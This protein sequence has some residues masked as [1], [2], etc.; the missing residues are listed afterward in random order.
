MG[1]ARAPAPL[2]W[3]LLPDCDGEEPEL[4]ALP[5]LVAVPV[6]VGVADEAGYC[7]PSALISKG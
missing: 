2:C 1:T 5:E 3:S 6:P 7:E 4:V